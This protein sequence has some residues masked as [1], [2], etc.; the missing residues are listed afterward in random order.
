MN[1]EKRIEA[2]ETKS[3]NRGDVVWTI[4]LVAMKAAGD[5]ADNVVGYDC[6]EQSW[7]R[8]PGESLDALKARVDEGLHRNALQTGRLVSLVSERYTE[9]SASD[10]A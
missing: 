3:G 6:G 1:L 2:L 8:L 4:F 7:D 10:C 5:D 9:K